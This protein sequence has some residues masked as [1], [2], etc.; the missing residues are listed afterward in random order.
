MRLKVLVLVI[1]FFAVA[2][3]ADIIHVPGDYPTIQQ[4]ID[5]ANPG[6]IVMVAPGTYV[7]E[8]T[9]KADVDVIGAGEGLSIIDGGGDQG[10]VV[11]AIGVGITNDTK[12]Q[13][14]T[15]TGANY[16]GMPGGGGIFC[17]MSASPEICNNRVEINSSGIATWNGS[18]P[19]IH[20]NV[21]IDNTY[22][23]ISISSDPDVINN[24][25]AN[26]NNGVYDS[27]GYQPIIMNNIVTGNSNIGMGCVNSSVPTDFSYND[28]WGNGQN[29]YNCSAGPGDISA[30]PLYVDETNGNFHLQAGSPCIDSGN[31]NPAYNDPDGTRNDMGAYGGP[32]ATVNMPRISLTIPSQNECNVPYDTDVSAVFNMD[33][34]PLTFTSLSFRLNGYFTGFYTGTI[35]YDSVAKMVTLDPNDNFAYGEVITSVLTHDIQSLFG[36][37]LSGFVWQF[38]SLVEDGSGF[39]TLL[40]AYAAANGPNSVIIAD[41][42]DDGKLDLAVTNENSN[43]VSVLLGNGDGSF[44]SASNFSAGATPYAICSGNFDGDAN[45]DLAVANGG[46]N[47]VSI[48]LGNGSGGFGSVTNYSVGSLPNALCCGDFNFDGYIDL[49]VANA[50]SNNVSIL[51]GNGD[52]SFGTATDFSV[53]T[54]PHS[55]C[56]GDFDNDGIFDLVTANGGTNNVSILLGNGDGN[57][58]SATNYSAGSVPYAVCTGDF[59]GNGN[60]DLGV[61]NGGSNNVSRLTGNGDGSF[62]S[63]VN[64]TAGTTPYSIVTSDFDG[65]GYFDLATANEG[66][67]NISVLLGNGDGSFASANNYSC[68]NNPHSVAGGDFD[69]DG[70]IDLCTADYNDNNVSILLNENE[71]LVISTNPVQFELDVLNSTDVSGTFNMDLNASSVDSSTFLL[72]GTQTGPHTGVVTYDSSTVTAT[73]DPDLDF[74]EGEMVTALLTKDVQATTGVYLNGFSWNFTAEVTTPSSGTF[75]TANNY[76]AGTEPRGMFAADLDFDGDIDI[77]TVL[78]NYPNPGALCVLLNNGNGTFGSPS[79]YSLGA[80][81]PLSVFG[82]DL[83]GDGDIDM[84]TAHNEPGTSHLVIMKNNGSGVFSLYASYAPAVLGQDISGGDFDLDGDIDLVM[85]DSWGS[86]PCVLVMFNNGNGNF[87]GPYAYSTGFHTRGL[88]AADVENDGDIDIIVSDNASSISILYNDGDGDFPTLGVYTTTSNPNGL[89]V[90]DLDGDG[91]ADIAAASYAGDN[92]QVLLNNGN[93][94]FGSAASYNTG[95]YTRRIIGGDYDGDGDID[96]SVSVNGTDSVAVILNNGNGTYANLSKYQVGNK[97]WGIKNGDFDLDG[98]IDISCANFDSANV[99]ILFNTGVSIEEGCQ[100]M[101]VRKP[102]L[103]IF[104]NPFRDKTVI[105]FSIPTNIEFNSQLSES[106]AAQLKIYDAAGRVVRNFSLLNFNFSP[107]LSVVWDGKDKKGN[108]L[109]SGIYFCQL[110]AGSTTLTHKLLRLR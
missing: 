57:F 51:L 107:P 22:T 97:P 87:S 62:G 38:T 5:A 94:T 56:A 93:G 73:I 9:L 15:V 52:G 81:D 29:Y 98:D 75:G 60:L 80:A 19:Y 20:N 49:A 7:E 6:D 50:N 108:I 27:G 63:P 11:T 10:D 83:D 32:G 12:F 33:M 59:D 35:T 43:N 3:L 72:Y 106:L 2:V 8:I 1:L 78:S 53:G 40:T 103:R 47:N 70:D 41:F 30:N 66:S 45:L 102:F 65:D 110:K 25:I 89:Y 61:A 105:E 18:N 67:D 91:Y 88:A 99:S 104:P 37:S 90:N 34:D 55:V 21:V 96:L 14:F 24:T 64:Y 31:P 36:D 76:T 54:S 44:G 28:V 71:L 82:A 85:G 42:N 68:G 39:Y 86:N 84:A 13:G 23:G 109:P 100:K 74:I 48:L 79:S 4:G 26:N 17:N 16:G 101:I 46:S 95:S 69:G 77:V 92:I 58:A